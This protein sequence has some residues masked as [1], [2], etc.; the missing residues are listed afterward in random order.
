MPSAATYRI[1]TV[2]VVVVAVLNCTNTFS[3]YDDCV[4]KR[5]IRRRR[6]EGVAYTGSAVVRLIISDSA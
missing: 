2:V 1:I 6:I 3:I 4:H 5:V